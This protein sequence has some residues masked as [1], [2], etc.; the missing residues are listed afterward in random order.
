MI[1]LLVAHPAEARPL[2]ERYGL[3]EAPAGPFPLFR[4]DSMVL[5]ISGPGKTAT[6][7]AAGWLYLAAG[8]VADGAWLGVGMAGHAEME[9]G[10]GVL[11][12]KVVDAGTGE[13]WYPP[14]VLEHPAPSATVITVDK[15]EHDYDGPPLYDTEAAGFFS[16][17]ARFATAELVHAFRIV[18]DNHGATLGDN[19]APD[20][21]EDLVASKLGLL[22]GWI[23]ELKEMSEVARRGGERA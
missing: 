9:I 8:G 21:A 23:E 18:A 16:A 14:I 22:D 20:V 7:A 4:G 17:A 19:F 11:A 1:H 10:S 13:S 12:H 15:L 2:V 5:A 3:R 6:A